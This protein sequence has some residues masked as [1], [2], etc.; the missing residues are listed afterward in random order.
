VTAIALPFGSMIVVATALSGCDQLPGRPKSGAE[1]P[2]PDQVLSFEALYRD[3]CSG[4]HGTDGTKGPATNLANPEYQALVDDATLRAIIANGQQGSMMPGFAKASGGTLTD[5]QV[6][7]LVHGI[8][9]QW[10]KGDVLQGL[11]APPY[12][13]DKTGDPVHGKQ[14]YSTNCAR[15]HGAPGGPPGAKGAILDGAFLSL[16]ADQTIRTT[17]IVGRPDLGMPDWRHQMPEHPMSD[18]DITDTVAFVVSQ[19]PQS[20]AQPSAS[21]LPRLSSNGNRQGGS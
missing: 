2:R 4:C 7:V 8:R 17:A 12:R 19:R 20:L 14:V 21:K 16:V 13:T 1:V 10:F 15:C 3:N 9:S 11:N 5:Q 6:D 18:Q